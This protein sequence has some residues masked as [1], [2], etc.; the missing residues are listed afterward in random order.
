VNTRRE[1]PEW[2]PDHSSR[3]WDHLRHQEV[4]VSEKGQIEGGKEET[5]ECWSFLLLF[6]YL[7]Y[8]FIVVL[9]R[10]TS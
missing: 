1:E 8:F 4:R 3:A 2:C 6:F 5:W 10:G 9:A 7:F